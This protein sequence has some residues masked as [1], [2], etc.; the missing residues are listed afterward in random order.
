M[1][2]ECG[3]G[4]PECGRHEP[5]DR[6][7]ANDSSTTAPS[8][9]PVLRGLLL[10]LLQRAR[11]WRHRKIVAFLMAAAGL[12]V[13]VQA[14]WLR[15]RFTP[16]AVLVWNPAVLTALGLIF[17]AVSRGEEVAGLAVGAVVGFLTAIAVLW[18]GSLTQL[19]V[20]RGSS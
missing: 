15:G 6:R 20:A 1:Y 4:P 9:A 17:G 2:Q 14:T 7:C 10:P 5:G 12:F 11:R 16:A 13:V 19:V 3:R 8:P 18:L